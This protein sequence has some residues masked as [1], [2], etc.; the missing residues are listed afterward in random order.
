MPR[1][2][3]RRTLLLI[4]A[5]VALAL[6]VAAAWLLFNTRNRVGETLTE[7]VGT[8]LPPLPTVLA[9][10]AGPAPG[11]SS[12]A[13]DATPSP[14]PIIVFRPGSDA[15]LEL[16][17]EAPPTL[18]ELLIRYPQLTLRR[19]NF[20]LNDP[21]R[22]REIYEELVDLY[23][24]EGIIGL[25]LFMSETGILRALNLDPTY[26]DFVLA[27]E[28]GGIE[29][30]EA[31][32]RQR[33][34]LTDDDQVRAVLILDTEDVTLVEPAL[35]EAGIAVLSHH[36]NEVEVGIP[37]AQIEA[38]ASSATL[39]QLVALAHLPHV[40]TIRAP[41]SV[42]TGALP[43]HNE[44]TSVTLA[45]AWHAAGYTGQGVRVGIIDPDG[46]AGYSRL[47]G[48]ELPV[49]G[50][51]VLAPWTDAEQ[52]DRETGPHGTACAE[53][54]YDM[55][56]D[57][58]LYLAYSGDSPLG[59]E[60]AIDWMIA[61][62]VDIISY[63]ASS[64]VEP[65]DGSSQSDQLVAR[66]QNAGIL[67]VNASG[68]YA[69]SHLNM[70]FTDVDGDGYHEFPHGDELLPIYP[71]RLSS[72]GLRWDE[73]WG[74]ADED[75]DLY[76]YT[77][78]ANGEPEVVVSSR[79]LQAGRATDLPYE[80]I[81]A[82][83]SPFGTYYAAIQEDGISRPGRLDLTGWGMMFDYSMPE[84]SLGSPADA[85]G[86]LAVGATFWRDDVLERYSSQGPTGDGRTKPDLAAPVRVSNATYA[87]FE[88]T[89]AAAP[90]V[91]GAAALVLSAHPNFDARQLRDFLTSRALDRGAAGYDNQFGAGRLDLQQPPGAD[92]ASRTAT[93]ATAAVHNVRLSHNQT[94]S[95]I[96][97]VVIYTDFSVDGLSARTG[98]VTA[99]F[100]DATGRPLPD[101]NGDFTDGTGGVAV[102]ATFSA[103]ADS[104]RATEYPLFMPYNELELPPGEHSILVTVTIG[105]ETGLALATSAPVSLL[106]RRDDPA[107]R[108]ATIGPVDVIHNVV[109]DGMAGMDI[110]VDFDALNFRGGAGTLAAYFYRGDANNTPLDDIN[111]QYRS[112]NGI[113]AVGRTFTPGS[114]AAQFRDFILFMPYGEL[115][116]EAGGRYDLKL[117]IIIWDDSTGQAI[118]VSDWVNFWFES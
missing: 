29:A 67:W 21:R 35:A 104:A 70:V 74:R 61:N 80:L 101:G 24:A 59:L 115:H 37:L 81:D 63:S 49:A 93:T 116:M 85:F 44:G 56:P 2:T 26:V 54:V 62:D 65:L 100:S 78:G 42:P 58:T 57:A 6:L 52:L 20:D 7:I 107:A 27:Y 109:R 112:G 31:L 87:V 113:V 69:Q 90:H 77:L 12:R 46:F 97:G 96:Y 92:Q 71:A 110:L 50:R 8:P 88:G 13:G 36:G 84:G 48:S 15:S 94:I 47:M 118:T 72:L 18:A 66:A 89:S 73:P 16:S 3:P 51:I 14:T 40:I 99:R 23:K 43:P 53:I 17:L 111:D 25:D 83:L 33:R 103:T 32:A 75:Y 91:A 102:S 19:E 95:G 11:M 117:H 64:L 114:N 60:R 34:I 106:V 82:E 86:A 98:T 108:Q 45:T 4:T 55:A 30:A 10:P 1:H 41:K 38:A 39:A 105:D 79:Y 76:I 28:T 5:G 68:N 9:T 22:L